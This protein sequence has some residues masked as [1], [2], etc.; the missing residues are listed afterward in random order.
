V[1]ATAYGYVVPL[2]VP[3]LRIASPARTAVFTF[4]RFGRASVLA[5][6]TFVPSAGGVWMRVDPG[7]GTR[8]CSVDLL[9]KDRW[10]ATSTV[11][12]S[13]DTE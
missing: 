2:P 4:S 11:S 10:G 9:W 5:D 1:E 8:L 13:T 3:P 7:D 6:S 12:C